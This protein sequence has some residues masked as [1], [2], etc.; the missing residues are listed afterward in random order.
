MLTSTRNKLCVLGVAAFT[1]FIAQGVYHLKQDASPAQYY[2][3]WPTPDWQDV[4]VLK[5]AVRFPSQFS[6][7]SVEIRLGER[8]FVTAPDGQFQI[9]GVPSGTH[10][11]RVE[12]WGYEHYLGRF[13]IHTAQVLQLP[14]ITLRAAKG[15]I[16]GRITNQGR[17]SLA[18]LTVAL[19]P[20]SVKVKTDRD[21]VFSFSCVAAG[22]YALLI[23]DLPPHRAGETQLAASLQLKQSFKLKHAEYLNLGVIAT[24]GASNPSA[25]VSM[26]SHPPTSHGFHIPL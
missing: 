7:R 17:Q 21:G 19:Q 25:R 12:V 11:L 18:G 13:E 2:L 4:G 10:H 6:Q 22:K 20:G 9:E 26:R 8:I 24:G 1:V 16:L 15:Q 23:A 14:Q 3:R 5:G